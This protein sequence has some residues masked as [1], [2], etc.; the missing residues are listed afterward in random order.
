VWPSP[1]A[2]EDEVLYFLLVD[3]FSDGQE[4]RYLDLNGTPVAGTTPLYTQADNGNA[5]RNDLDAATWRGAGTSWVG[6]TLNGLRTKFGYLSRLGV[7]TLWISPV[8]KQA[9]AP[10]GGIANYHGY[11]TQDFLS[12]EP[13]FGT[14]DEFQALVHAAHDAGYG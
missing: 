2:W 14:N 6:G 1:P 8:L 10:P 12:V 4:D 11:A 9:W 7:T 13:R 5:V 3:R